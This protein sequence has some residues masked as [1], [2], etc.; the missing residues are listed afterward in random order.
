MATATT[1]EYWVPNNNWT[2]EILGRGSYDPEVKINTINYL[3]N[4][5]YLWE[6]YK[7]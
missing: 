7:H 5:L 3:I 1:K 2:K 6:I 4:G